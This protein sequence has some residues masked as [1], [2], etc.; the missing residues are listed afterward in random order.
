MNIKNQFVKILFAVVIAFT[1]FSCTD[2]DKQEITKLPTIVEIASADANYSI[3]VRLVKTCN[4][5]NT[6]SAPGSYT[7]FVPDNAAFATIGI[8]DATIDVLD[9]NPL[10]PANATNIATYKKVLQN[11]V[12]N[13]GTR[14]VDLIPS[15]SNSGYNK[16]FATVGT[17]TTTFFSFY[18]NNSSGVAKVNGGSALTGGADVVRQDIDASNGIVHLIDRVLAFPKLT[19]FIAADPELSVLNTIIRSTATS[20]APFTY[21]D[22][23]A[24]F[25]V[26]NGAGPASL[27][28][29]INSAFVTATTG[30]GFYNNATTAGIVTPA[31]TSKLLQYH[32]SGAFLTS[33]S[34]TSWT[35]ATA[36]TDVT[37]TTLAATAQKFLI[38]KGTL[39]ITELPAI[40]LPAIVP[41]VCNIK[42]VNIIG[43]NGNLHIIDRVLQPILP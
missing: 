14:I 17:S 32:A 12:V 5:A 29:P 39:K 19:T 6:F 38:T 21:G 11:H 40:V 43:S 1:A 36:T 18:V 25:G 27:F 13:I 31:N 28:A 33:A 20:V 34:A 41:P 4:L 10:L 8:T 2:E 16:S 26:L 30:T 9:A 15:V 37:V 35:S 24:V 42:T 22:Q 3:F 7:V 23:T